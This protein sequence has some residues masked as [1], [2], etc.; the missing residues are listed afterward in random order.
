MLRFCKSQVV[1]LTNSESQLFG[2]PLF[3]QYDCQK[4]IFF[5]LYAGRHKLIMLHIAAKKQ[6]NL[7]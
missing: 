7:A 2:T 5:D 4:I 3:L 6:I 1:K